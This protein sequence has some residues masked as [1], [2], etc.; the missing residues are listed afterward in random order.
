MNRNLIDYILNGCWNIS[1]LNHVLTPDVVN[2]ILGIPL[3]ASS[4]SDEFV[5]GPSPNGIFSIKSATWIQCNMSMAWG[6]Y[7]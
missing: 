4:I 2:H 5:W 3:P 6:A 1:K 7:M